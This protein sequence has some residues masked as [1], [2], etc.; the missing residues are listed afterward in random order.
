VPSRVGRRAELAAQARP[1][2]LLF[3]PGQHGDEDGP[4]GHDLTRH[5]PSATKAAQAIGAAGVGQRDHHMRGVGVW[6][7]L[8]LGSAASARGEEAA[9]HAGAGG[10]GAVAL[11]QAS[12]PTTGGDEAA[13]PTQA[14]A[15]TAKGE[16]AVVHADA[17]IVGE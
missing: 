14:G 2:G 13:A 17:A 11:A 5:Y 16:G 4:T 3:R 7:T 15:P 8:D 6:W 10:E 9:A 12:S 1:Y